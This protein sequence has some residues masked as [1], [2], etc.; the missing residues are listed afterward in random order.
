M[1]AKYLK[2]FDQWLDS[3]LPNGMNHAV[4][5]ASIILTAYFLG[6][7][8]WALGFYIG[9]VVFFYLSEVKQA[10]DTQSCTFKEALKF[11]KWQLSKKQDV[12]YVVLLGLPLWIF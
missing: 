3:K 5:A 4:Y 1:I 6:G 7:F 12:A 10:M 9:A 11:W 8:Y 2:E